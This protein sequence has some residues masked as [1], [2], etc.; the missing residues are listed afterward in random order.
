VGVASGG[1]VPVP[2]D[3]D[4]VDDTVTVPVTPGAQASQVDRTDVLIEDPS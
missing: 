1:P 2:A 3:G 4:A